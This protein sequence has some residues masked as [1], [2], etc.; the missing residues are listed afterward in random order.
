MEV[1][2]IEGFVVSD[3]K[4]IVKP[5]MGMRNQLVN[6]P[7]HEAYFLFGNACIDY[8]LPVDSNNNLINPFSSK[9]EQAWLEKQLDLDLNIYKQKKDNYWIK[10]KVRLGKN[11]RTLVLSNPKDYIDYLILKANK[12]WIAP[13]GESQKKKASYRYALVTEEYETQTVVSKSDKKKKAYKEAGNM[14]AKGTETM[15]NFLKTYGKRVDPKSKE[16]FLIAEIDKII[17]ED[18]DGFLK[19]VGDSDYELRLLLA[20]AVEIGAINKKGRSYTLP[21]GDGLC[22]VGEVPTIENAIVYLK[23]PMNRDV[24]DML[25]TRVKAGK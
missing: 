8:R 13:D 7:N 4:I 15:V 10:H 19:I 3:K 11:P 17:E 6:D 18:L 16:P 1:K 14:E 5:I 23:N 9:D 2:T 22:G 21:G 24:L 12:L 25:R 20:N